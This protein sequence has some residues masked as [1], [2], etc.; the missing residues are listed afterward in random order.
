MSTVV[1]IGI[2]L[3]YLL[4][5]GLFTFAGGLSAAGEAIKNWGEAA[6][7]RPQSASH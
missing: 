4:S 7:G 6:A 2:G 5:V 3:V 1:A